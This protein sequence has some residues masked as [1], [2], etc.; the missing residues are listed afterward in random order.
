MN[1]ILIAI[2]LLFIV[3]ICNAQINDV[4][5]YISMH[6]LDSNKSEVGVIAN[7]FS[8]SNSINNEFVNSLYLNKYI[9]DDQKRSN[10]IKS[11]NYFGNESSISTYFIHHPD[12]LFNTNKFGYRIGIED[13][14]HRDVKFTDDLYNPAGSFTPGRA[15]KER[16]FV[17][18]R[19]VAGT[20]LLSS[21]SNFTS[22][23]AM[24]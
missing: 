20:P 6:N 15:Y 1:K 11:M 7:I 2:L 19:A 21:T 16:F 4:N 9:S 24:R 14:T 22:L 23:P 5:R 10:N 18:C 17:F 12:S 3:S 13:Y 8:A